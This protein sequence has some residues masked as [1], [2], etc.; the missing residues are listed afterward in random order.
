MATIFNFLLDILM[1]TV[2][3]FFKLIG[4][5]IIGALTLKEAGSGEAGQTFMPKGMLGNFFNLFIPAGT[6]GATQSADVPF[7]KII[8]SKSNPYHY[9]KW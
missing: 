8:I 6:Q 9:R 1:S 4:G 2:G 7:L 3:F 5:F